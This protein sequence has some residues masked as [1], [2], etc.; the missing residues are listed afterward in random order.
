MNITVKE[1]KEMAKKYNWTL[2]HSQSSVVVPN[3]TLL[4]FQSKEG[5]KHIEALND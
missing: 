4:V 5:E 1:A 3:A 2:V